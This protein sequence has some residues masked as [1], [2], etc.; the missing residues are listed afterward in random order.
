MIPFRWILLALLTMLALEVSGQQE[1]S[2][3]S[4]AKPFNLDIVSPVYMGGSDQASSQFM[5]QVLPEIQGLLSESLSEKSAVE[6]ISALVLDPSK[7]KLA[8]DATARVYF[9]G[10]GAGF[11][12]TLG[13]QTFSSQGELLQAPTLTESAELIFPNASSRLG[14][15]TDSK[16]QG[17]ARTMNEPVL[18]GDFVELGSFDSGTFLDFFLIANGAKGGTD[19]FVAEGD[20]N[21]DGLDHMIA[22]GLP[23]SPFLVLGF[24]DLMGGGDRDYN[25]LLFAVDIGALNIKSLV[26]APEPGLWAMILGFLLILLL[27]LRRSKPSSRV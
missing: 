18:P 5:T 25:D 26:S 10:E 8:T 17:I 6:N 22:F 21:W 9:I 1:A 11:Y 3:Q 16:A 12:N 13:F 7:L 15:V 27:C 23:G 19:V 24:E 20:R 4:K 2:P 14:Y